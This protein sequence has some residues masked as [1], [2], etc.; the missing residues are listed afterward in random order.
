[1]VAAFPD[2]GGLF[3]ALGFGEIPAAQA[4]FTKK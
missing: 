1:M 3:E 4:K 2:S